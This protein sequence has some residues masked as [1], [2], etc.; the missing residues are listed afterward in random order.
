MVLYI[1]VLFIYQVPLKMEEEATDL[2][3]VQRCPNPSLSG[4]EYLHLDYS[5]LGQKTTVG[6]LAPS[7][8]WFKNLERKG[9]KDH[10]CI[11]LQSI[12][13]YCA[14]YDYSSK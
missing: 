6:T 14:F 8:W 10:L 3:Q 7:Q 1:L 12:G 9:N 11:L 5:G 2:S 13:K 4:M